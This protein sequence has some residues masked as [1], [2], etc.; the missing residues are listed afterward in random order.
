M[1]SQTQSCLGCWA[2]AGWAWPGARKCFSMSSQKR[3]SELSA[4]GGHSISPGSGLS[5]VDSAGTHA[6]VGISM[7][8]LYRN[9]R[10][11]GA[12][13][14]GHSSRSQDMWCRNQPRAGWAAVWGH[15]LS[16]LS[17]PSALDPPLPAGSYDIPRPFGSNPHLERCQ[18]ALSCLEEGTKPSQPSRLRFINTFKMCPAFSGCRRRGGNSPGS[19]VRS[20]VVAE[21][22]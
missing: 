20:V 18:Q 2:G 6:A 8:L 19:A 4:P 11:P 5:G 21:A 9:G 16:A 3:G 13:P 12:L 15:S 14:V 10:W 17:S 22:R 7:L 1:K